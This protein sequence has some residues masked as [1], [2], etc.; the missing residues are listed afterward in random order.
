MQKAI[1]SYVEQ[2]LRPAV[3]EKMPLLDSRSA[4]N[5]ASQPKTASRGE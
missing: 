5:T 1:D 4:G 2:V 3:D